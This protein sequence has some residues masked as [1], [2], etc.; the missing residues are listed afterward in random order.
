MKNVCCINP[1]E[2]N[3]IISSNKDCIVIDCRTSEEIKLQCLDYDINIDMHDP[4]A[5]QLIQDLDPTKSYIAYCKGG[6]RSQYLCEILLNNGFE[7]VYNLEGGIL[8]WN[9]YKMRNLI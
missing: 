7:T 9:Q 6:G 4:S 3:D 5:L 8:N 1:K 2:F